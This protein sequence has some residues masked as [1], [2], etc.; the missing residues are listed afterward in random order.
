V[1]ARGRQD[2]TGA[3]SGQALAAV[4]RQLERG[5]RPHSQRT[6]KRLYLDRGK[7]GDAWLLPTQIQAVI[8]RGLE[9]PEAST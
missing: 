1:L 9:V 3:W 8:Q 2:A 4:G 6:R 7:T 5:V